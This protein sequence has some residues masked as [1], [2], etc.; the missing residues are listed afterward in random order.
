MPEKSRSLSPTVGPSE[1]LEVQSSTE[2][3][4]TPTFKHKSKTH[5]QKTDA[6][7]FFRLS[8]V[9]TSAW[10][11]NGAHC[12]PPSA[13]RDSFVLRLRCWP[14]S[15]IPRTQTLTL[16]H[17]EECECLTYRPLPAWN[18][19]QESCFKLQLLLFSLPQQLSMSFLIM[20]LCVRPRPLT[21]TQCNLFNPPLSRADK[22]WP[23]SAVL[24]LTQPRGEQFSHLITFGS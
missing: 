3:A 9:C 6:L 10:R 23:P 22:A 13:V 2:G 11:T 20:F 16:Y 4:I 19:T 21:Q 18:N 12:I 8:V 17:Y 1:V 15:V 5:N 14:T 24:H 7:I